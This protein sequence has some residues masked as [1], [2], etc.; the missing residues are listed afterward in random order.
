MPHSYSESEIQNLGDDVSIDSEEFNNTVV[1]M[2]QLTLG[3]TPLD[4]LTDKQLEILKKFTQM[5]EDDRSKLTQLQQYYCFHDRFCFV[6]YLKAR[7]WDIPNATKLLK[8]S[9][10]W[11]ESSY[12]PFS[13]TAKQLW[14]EASPAKT[15][16]KGHD[17]A[18]RPIIYLHAGRD[19]T[20]DPATGVSLLV[21]NLIAASYRMGP[22]GSQMTWI[23][24]FSSYTTKS[25]PP[26]AVCK[27]AVEILSSH[28]PER[29][30][31]CLM[32]FAPKVFYWFFKLISPLIPPVTKQKIQFCKGTK[33]KDM[34]AFF[35]PFVDMSQLEKK[36]GGDQ[37]F[38]YNHKE[39]WAHEIEH[40]LKRLHKIKEAG[41]MKPEEADAL[42]NEPII[43]TL[44][45][46]N[47]FF[48][49]RHA[50]K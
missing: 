28:F 2:D 29:L 38:T 12:K 20:N 23:C 30:G 26:L 16:I 17:K 36:Y 50:S 33:Q 24:D 46:H 34:R 19:F 21:Y 35:E 6:R 5:F 49:A 18:G 44:E 42:I 4:G 3:S 1:A 7:D 32:V 14:L 39:M 27:Q 31:L 15:Y 43:D 41:G 40:D 47:K 10:T 8:S 13:L 48:K 37:D 25:A 9:L 11:I 45:K 22:N